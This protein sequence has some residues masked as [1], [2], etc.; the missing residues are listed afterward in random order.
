MKRREEGRN[1]I[2]ISELERIAAVV[3]V[4]ALEMVKEALADYGGME[5]LLAE[6]APVSEPGSAVNDELAKKR[7]A[8]EA[9]FKGEGFDETK[10]PSAAV[11]NPEHEQPEPGN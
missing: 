10:Y 6:Y 9:K 5:K 3:N 8:K 2:T 4:S 1:E 7:E 11:N